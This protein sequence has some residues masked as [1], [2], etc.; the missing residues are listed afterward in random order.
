MLGWFK[1]KGDLPSAG[2]PLPAAPSATVKRQ[3]QAVAAIGE[4]RVAALGPVHD[5]AADTAAWQA[6]LDAAA[7]DDAALLDIARQAP[8]VALQC[9]AVAA[10]TDEAALRRAERDLRGHDRRVHRAAKQRH[11]AA[12]AQRVARERAA[13]LI[14]TAQT[15]LAEATIPTNRL[16][17]LDRSW[18][19]LD[20]ALLSEAQKAEFVQI[21]N[22]LTELTRERGERELQAQRWLAPARQ[23][24][25][26]L[27][28][29]CVDA[30]AGRSERDDLARATQAALACCGAAPVLAAPAAQSGGQIGTSASARA[31]LAVDALQAELRQACEQAEQIDARLAVLADAMAPADADA[32]T[33][34]MPD[35]AS[36]PAGPSPGPVDRWQALPPLADAAIAAALER[37]FL[38][39]HNR[40]TAAVPAHPADNLAQQS[41]RPGAPL[42][43]ST[44][45]DAAP[46]GA[47][48]KAANPAAQKAA[49]REL[50]AA[51][52]PLLQQA[53]A[54]L[55]A[56]NLAETQKLL[57]AID[58]QSAGSTLPHAERT[59]VQALH[60]GHARLKGWQRWGGGRARDD[61]VQ[62][63]QTLATATAAA[64]ADPKQAAKLPVKLLADAIDDLRKRW[65]EL[66]RLGGAGNQ[67]LW[68]SFDTALKTAYEP[69]AAHLDQQK[70]KRKENLAVR[71]QLLD[72]LERATPA[73]ADVPAPTAA[74]DWREAA[75]ALAHFQTEW[76]KLGPV[77]HTVPHKA[78]EALLARLEASVARIENPLQQARDAAQHEREQLVARA[79]ALRDEA[80][81]HPHTRE[82]PARVRELQEQWQQHAKALPLTR[83]VEAA[84]WAQF[85][86][87]TDAVF[88][89][90]D[91]AWSARDAELQANQAAREALIARLEALTPQTPANEIRRTVA[92]VD[93]QWRVPVDVPRPQVA[94][95]DARFHTA[96]RA[97]DAHIADAARAGRQARFDALARKLALCEAL[98]RLTTASAAV[99]DGRAGAARAAAAGDDTDVPASEAVTEPRPE[100]DLDALN[101]QWAALASSLPPLPTSWEQALALRLQRGQRTETPSNVD[102][103]AALD[104]LLLQLE[105]ALDVPSPPAHQAARRDLK[106]QAMKAALESRPRA[107]QVP[108]S[109]DELTAAALACPRPA[110]AQAERL[111]AVL[112][113][114]RQR[115]GDAGHR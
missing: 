96:R 46:S 110:P 65:K 104:A 74:A 26:A 69:V 64:L 4:E 6:R 113:A 109:A 58:A 92:E 20:A 49:R 93:A 57:A 18:Q 39:W 22:R 80:A 23:A 106:L 50:A 115:E 38:E 90:R 81:A 41:A 66:D 21:S 35:P 37:R 40:A 19:A 3:A 94:V 24:L 56:G 111:R 43:T 25:A 11:D 70:A 27:N 91:A 2:G 75:R 15:L 17:E 112:Q 36:T 102:G 10:I 73:V 12:A 62:E 33:P 45:A 61:L 47:L 8:S 79:Q 30:A 63:A 99:A 98:E 72:D 29:T 100:S 28:R 5:K 31:G 1:K 107:A 53:E 71:L 54:A 32:P 16:V 60:A 95:L 108:A 34:A 101:T 9:A 48:D 84:L 105:A 78:Q 67:T 87:A 86:A 68:H 82:L 51:L 89:Q 88:T 77:E 55:E 42:R 85:K 7:G 52:A 83:P 59:R 44:A 114:W 103:G 13:V 97:A 76:R 14:D